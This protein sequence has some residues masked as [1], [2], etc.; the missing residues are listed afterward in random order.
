MRRLPLLLLT[1]ATATLLG[2]CSAATPASPSAPAATLDGRT[3]LSTDIQGMTLAQDT[4][5]TLTFSDGNLQAQGGCNS[6]GGAYTIDGDQLKTGQMSMTEMACDEPRMAQDEWLAG[7]LSDATV[8]LDGDTLTLDDGTVTLTLVDKEV[9]TPDQPLE[10]TLWVV[11]GIV[12][13]DAVSSVPQGVTAS[14]RIV[15]G[16]AEVR[17]GC[18]TGGGPVEVTADT[19]GAMAME[20]AVGAVLT[21]EVDYAIDAD[22]LTLDAGANGLIL[23]A[24]P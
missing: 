2:A 10:G 19:G 8:T 15:D 16:Q 18:N 14:M 20:T 9:A 1:I 5:V 21:G 11:D 3:F 12:T 24:T 13:G 23:R 4:R 22:V 7:F 6:M 17:F